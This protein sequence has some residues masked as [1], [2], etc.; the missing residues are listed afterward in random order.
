[1]AYAGYIYRLGQ[2]VE[3]PKML[4]ASLESLIKHWESFESFKYN[5]AAEFKVKG[6]ALSCC[7]CVTSDAAFV[8]HR[9]EWAA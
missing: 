7:V 8:A 2:T 6:G 9:F 5:G 3:F 4:F 1:M